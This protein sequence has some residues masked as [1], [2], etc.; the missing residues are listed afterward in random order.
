MSRG[1]ARDQ[2]R[3]RGGY[4]RL[5]R[6][7]RR[8]SPGRAG[9]AGAPPRVV[10]RDVGRAFLPSHRPMRVR[11][12]FDSPARGVGQ[13]AQGRHPGPGVR[14]HPRGRGARRVRAAQG[15]PYPLRRHTQHPRGLVRCGHAGRGPAAVVQ[16]PQ[17]DGPRV[18]PGGARPGCLA[19]AHVR[20]PG[21]LRRHS[22]RFPAPRAGPVHS[23]RH[24]FAA[25]V[26]LG[27]PHSVRVPGKDV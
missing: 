8:F 1:V 11:P 10:P 14:S 6:G 12:V 13:A 4:L 15:A 24:P 17:P 27:P 9:V 21:S 19:R 23:A 20:R 26:G 7:F 2:R 25:A 16:P 5:H 18:D 22:R 3:V